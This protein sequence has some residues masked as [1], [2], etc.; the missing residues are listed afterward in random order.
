MH[1]A[2]D[3]L[4]SAYE[5][6]GAERMSDLP[7]FNKNMLVEAVGF[8]IWERRYAGIVIT[9][10]FMNFVIV[11]TRQEPWMQMSTGST[12]ELDF[13]SGLYS[14][15]VC[16]TP[17]ADAHLGLSLFST[18]LGFPNQDTARCVAGE[19]LT[20]L[21]ADRKRSVES[22][23]ETGSP[24]TRRALLRGDRAHSFFAGPMDK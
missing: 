4:T 11:P 8:R 3:R 7:V 15:N 9:P 16:R 1:A 24:L 20:E 21:F 6:I 5:Q 22:R 2:I 13:P 17:D 10:W 19:I 18:V 23:D 12:V 14:L